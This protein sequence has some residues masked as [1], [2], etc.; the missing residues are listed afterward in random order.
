MP[1]SLP[2]IDAT[3]PCDCAIAGA[4]VI[5]EGQA[6]EI[7]VRLKALADPTRI[8]LLCLLLTEGGGLRTVDLAGALGVTEPTVSHHLKTL[9]QT[10]LV[11][12]ERVDDGVRYR[13]QLGSL[14]A[15]SRAIDPC[16]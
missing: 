7:A 14:S 9:A 8:R 2:L 13:A 15:L 1:R 12:G 16:C 10:G 6:L 3:A 11:V 5:S 4:G